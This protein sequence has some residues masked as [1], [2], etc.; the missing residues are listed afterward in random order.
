MKKIFLVVTFIVVT[1]L[2]LGTQQ[3][4]YAK[5]V[6]T[7][8][9]PYTYYEEVD[10]WQVEVGRAHSVAITKNRN[11]YTWGYNEYG[12]LGD[13]TFED[14][15]E[16]TDITG[17]F[18]LLSGEVIK[19]ISVGWYHSSA[20]TTKGRVFVW[21]QNNWGQIGDNTTTNR[22]SPQDITENFN[23][24]EG[25]IIT[26]INLGSLYSAAITSSGRVFTW[27][28]DNDAGQLGNGTLVDS[29][30]PTEITGNFNLEVGEIV[31]TINLGYSHSA[32]ITSEGRI[33]TWGQNNFG[34]LGD[35]STDDK[36]I[37]TDI[38]NQFTLNSDEKFIDLSLGTYHSTVITSAGRIF[39][40]G[41]N[42][43]GSL[44]DGTYDD[45]YIP[46]DI[47][48]QFQLEADDLIKKISTK[49]YL[50]SAVTS[51]G[52]VFTWGFNDNY[53]LGNG[54]T[55]NLNVPTEITNAFNLGEDNIY[56]ISMGVYHTLAT[57]SSGKLFGWGRNSEGQLGDGSTVAKNIPTMIEFISDDF[58]TVKRNSLPVSEEITK[59]S[60]GEGH[61]AIITS[62]GNL[63]IW[64][65]NY[66]GLLGDGTTIDKHEPINITSKFS[67]NL[68]E[69]IAC[70]SLGSDHSSAITSEGRV[71]TWGSN[72]KGQLGDSSYTNSLIPVDITSK[73][74]LNTGEMI[75]DIFLGGNYNNAGFSLAITSEGR[76]FTWGNNDKG[77]LGNSNTTNRNEPTEITSLFNLDSGEVITSISAGGSFSSAITSEGRVFMWGNNHRGQLGVGSTIN[78]Y[79]PEDIT[80]NFDLLPN[81]TIESIDLGGEHSSALTSYNRVFAWGCNYFGTVGDGTTIDR[82]LPKEI[83]SVFSLGENEIITNII[84][85]GSH[86]L[87][88][89]SE[90]RIFT[91]GY[92]HAGQLGNGTNS[93]DANSNPI[94]ITN[95]FSFISNEHIINISFG[96]AHSS[97]IT[98][99]GRLFTWGTNGMGQLGDGITTDRSIPTEINRIYSQYNE[100]LLTYTDVVQNYSS[101]YLKLSIFP[102]YE[103]IDNISNININGTEYSSVDVFDGRID[104]NISNDGSLGDTLTFDVQSITFANDVVMTLSGELTVLMILVE[105]NFAPIIYFDYD[106]N[107]YI[108]AN[109]NGDDYIQASAT[110]DTGDSVEVIITGNVDWAIPGEYELT[111]TSTDISG[112]EATKTRTIT[113]IPEI[114]SDSDDNNNLS[115][116]Y[117]GSETYSE[118]TDLTNQVIRYNNQNYSPENNYSDY[119]YQLFDNKIIYEFRIEDKLIF[120]SKS[121][122]Y[123]DAI[124][125]TFETIADQTI[126]A[127]NP[128]KDWS[129]MITNKA[130]NSSGTLTASEVTD[131]VDYDTP[132][133]YSVTVKLA[134][135]SGNETIQTFNVTVEDTTGPTFDTI[136]NQTI[137]AGTADI[138]WSIL[139]V[140]EA[141]NS[142][143][144][145]IS[146]E[147]NEN[148]NYDTPGTYAV[149]VKLVD[150]SGNETRQGFNVIVEDTT[151]P[152]FDVIADQTVEA[153]TVDIDWSSLIMNEADN[154]D[155]FLIPSEVIDNVDYDTLG[156]YTVTV[157]LVD[158][159]GNETIQTF[160]VTVEDT[161]GPNF[162]GLS[163]LEYI[164]EED[165][166]NYL[167]QIIAID[168][169]DG[170]LTSAI[171]V[172][173]SNV[174]YEI[175]GS[176]QV[177]YSV[178]DHSDN[179]TTEII[180]VIVK[181]ILPPEITLNG[182]SI[183]NVEAGSEFA[184][185]G[186]TCTDNYDETCT[187][188][189]EGDAV[190]INTLGTYVIIYNVTDTSGNEATEV[191]RTVNVLDTTAPE[192]S[193][194]PSLD[195]IT[196]GG[197]YT[198]QEVTV[199]DVTDTTIVIS[200]DTVDT[201]IP[202][203]YAI[204]YTVTDTSGN[205]TILKRYVTV[206][207]N[208]EVI[209]ILGNA[210][211]TIQTGTYYIDGTC[212]VSVNGEEHDCR[213]AD[214]T[215][216]YTTA[217]VYTITYEYD[218]Y[219]YKRYVF[220][221]DGTTNI[222]LYLPAKKEE[223]DLV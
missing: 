206:Y 173:D 47:T 175:I 21:G 62:S 102:E 174:N 49:W 32:A 165:A 13:D 204:T 87:A 139:I 184:D 56:S 61:S 37:P 100:V 12:Q 147:H 164:L 111:Y 71:F 66:R 11:I 130:D 213:V 157:K 78:K 2:F 153:M 86:S 178:S 17:N 26:F 77:Q 216:D 63:Y 117:F 137:E 218:D 85:G 14:R 207:E 33:F 220:V 144:I 125:P 92:N 181:D 83:T 96:E 101:N 126:E 172:D 94:D 129:T 8:D 19:M 221:V 22:N 127:G 42:E 1:I 197:L 195:S 131:G 194:N 189:I 121:V 171:I 188:I 52:R 6:P 98:S 57:T 95:N 18:N 158:E 110:D 168:I 140:N 16:P 169:M 27:G 128:D 79:S 39:T 151:N 193:L 211:T 97:V 215:V 199:T 41:Y 72:E 222:Q 200:G 15:Y 162:D 113:V 143:G 142:D 38:T 74:S 191:I 107:L 50:S 35:D 91:W 53:Q 44:G 30:V 154:S 55:D 7:E 179:I 9:E 212:K 20:L 123:P 136:A 25:E 109:L 68:G 159:S 58:L 122:Y 46:I 209:F 190:D 67:L 135:E 149:I 217:G 192:V 84:L 210:P 40:W 145:L 152:T 182:D 166:P 219:S 81:E 133:T 150:E 104:V 88:L 64:G 43:Y 28:G 73:F 105:D 202:G 29:H 214:N 99:K 161:T 146:S 106:E 186:T 90:D 80:S 201:S 148:V 82:Y 163:N 34:Q 114:T 65:S 51:S 5:M 75:T 170:D 120:V 69:T 4:I 176:Y 54:T 103:I 203:T 89:T 134:D 155:G 31:T 3:T 208:P 132:G 118:D 138:D 108:E 112:N 187:V 76:V 180:T 115:F 185:S 93:Y 23:L 205:E 141:D 45:K 156:D 167:A 36:Y 119:E 70:V 183:L 223:G 177:A 48:S 198:E 196:V 60:L 59:V 160:N 24:E 116:Y 10:F 124:S